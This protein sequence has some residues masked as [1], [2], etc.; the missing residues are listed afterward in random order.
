MQVRVV[1]SVGSSVVALLLGASPAG[2]SSPFK[3]Y[4][5]PG[6]P[7]AKVASPGKLAVSLPSGWSVK[8]AWPPKATDPRHPGVAWSLDAALETRG[9]T[10]ADIRTTNSWTGCRKGWGYE[11]QV[12]DNYLTLPLGRAWHYTM[13]VYA[14]KTC[15]SPALFDMDRYWVDRKAVSRTGQEVFL[16]FDTFCLTSQCETQNRRFATIMHS[17]RIAHPRRL[18]SLAAYAAISDTSA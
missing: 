18:P 8:T 3:Q 1:L 2:A 15:T 17:I 9:T 11:R 7:P 14:D 6:A 13:R 4:M 12:A 5:L 16:V 10:L